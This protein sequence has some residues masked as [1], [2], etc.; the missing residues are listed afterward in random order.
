MPSLKY[1]GSSVYLKVWKEGR[2]Y[3]ES[4]KAAEKAASALAASSFS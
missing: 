4:D 2:V 1:I 3:D